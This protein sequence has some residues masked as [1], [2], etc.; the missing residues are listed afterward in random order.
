MIQVLD[1]WRELGAT[2]EVTDE[3]D[4]WESRSEEKLRAALKKYDG[5]VA[6]VAGVLKDSGKSV[7]SPIFE[8]KDFERLEAAGEQE[9]KEQLKQLARER[10]I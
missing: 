4:F 9:F 8:R 2:A 5:L 1:F 10:I 6:A 7:A 3:G